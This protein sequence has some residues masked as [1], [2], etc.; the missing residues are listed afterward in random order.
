MAVIGNCMTLTLGKEAKEGKLDLSADEP[1]IVK[2]L[3]QYMYEADYDPIFSTFS[4]VINT[5]NSDSPQTA[6]HTCSKN[7]N[8]YL[9]NRFSQYRRVCP[10]HY[11]GKQ[12][13]YT[14]VDFICD[15]CITVEGDASQL[16]IH[17]KMYEMADKYDV[18]GL[19]ALSREKF[20]WAC[21][22]FWD[23]AEFAEAAYH[24]YTS[25]PDDDKGLRSIICTVLSN[26]MSLLLKAEVKGL[27]TEFN[28]LAFNLLMAK[29][30]QAGWC[31]RQ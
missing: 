10:H 8:D 28:G 1:A 30:E 14:C 19:K 4:N 18:I 29:A 2:S 11:C 5:G 22:K 24:A 27:V 6:A 17:V 3:I 7:P 9:C 16:L 31:N 12:C 25:T 26:H 20:H 15:Q 21:I 13:N 23:R